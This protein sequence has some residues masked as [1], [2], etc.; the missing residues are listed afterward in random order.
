MG[1]IGGMGDQRPRAW[2]NR[3]YLSLLA[4][5]A[6]DLCWQGQGVGNALLRDAMERT[7]QAAEIAG[8]RAFAVHAKDEEARPFYEQFDFVPSPADPMHLF[9]LLT[10]LRRIVFR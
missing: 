6:A 2:Q 5:L 10:D 4:R 7:L 1:P 9:V 3:L 8:I